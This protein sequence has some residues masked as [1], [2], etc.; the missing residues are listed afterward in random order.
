[1]ALL[2]FSIYSLQEINIEVYKK[3]LMKA[4][5]TLIENAILVLLGSL[6]LSVVVILLYN[7]YEQHLRTEIQNSL[8]QIAIDVSSNLLRLY[9][10]GKKSKI[11]V[12]ENQSKKILEIELDLP[13]RVSG[14]SYEVILV[15]PNPLWTTIS[16]VKVG[17]KE[18]VSVPAPPGAK[19]IA[20][21]TQKPFVTIEYE[22]PNIDVSLQGKTDGSDSKLRYYRYN[23]AGVTRDKIVLGDQEILMDV[24]S[25]G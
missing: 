9:E 3:Q 5:A 15:S 22:I 2:I 17:G 11:L 4:Q 7:F 8:T 16:L 20:R 25:V 10:A 14:R 21:T 24:T 1:M 6:M 19:V 13:E 18:V 23:I 12:A